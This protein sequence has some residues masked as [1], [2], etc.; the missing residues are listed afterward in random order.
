MYSSPDHIGVVERFLREGRSA[1]L[2]QAALETLAII[3]YRGPISRGR[4]G[5]IRGVGVDS[6]VR[7]L[8]TR[9]LIDEQGTDPETGA[10]L[11]ATTPLFLERMGMKS[12]DE[13]EAL[14]P[15]LPGQDAI[16]EIEENLPR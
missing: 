4:I 8:M 2:T 13:L 16:A 7:T 5:A 14:A 12:L 15:H 11:Y 9:G 3:A 6:V 1:K 10:I